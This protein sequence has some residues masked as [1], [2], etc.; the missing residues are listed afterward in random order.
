MLTAIGE[1]LD[2]LSDLPPAEMYVQKH[3]FNP[4]LPLPPLYLSINLLQF[5]L[6]ARS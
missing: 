6:E 3:S 1:P 5:N 2:S 4:S